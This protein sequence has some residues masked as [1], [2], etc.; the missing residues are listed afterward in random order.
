MM[1]D[2]L[3]RRTVVAGGVVGDGAPTFRELTRAES[4]R[5]LAGV[6]V[7]RIVFSH[8]A[9]P[10]ICPVNHLVDGEEVILSGPIR[11]GLRSALD[12]VVAYEA[13]HVDADGR[14]RWSVMVTGV[15]RQVTAPQ[16]A[17]RYRQV[18]RQWE[19]SDTDYIIRIRP[20]LVTGFT[21]D[22]ASSTNEH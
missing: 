21:L 15:A 13:D 9:L 7:G 18:L 1:T 2:V 5:L 14:I 6:G 22:E 19:A 10:A 11:A 16:D 20:E 3:R 12:T 17:V 4:L 8:Q